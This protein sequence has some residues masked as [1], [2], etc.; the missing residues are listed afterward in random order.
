MDD[1]AP[2][3]T[4]VVPTYNERPNLEELA[5]RVL[6]LGPDYALLVV[7][8]GSP[9]GTGA[10]ADALAAANPGRVSVLHRPRKEGIGPAYLAGFARALAAG[11]PL[12][13]QM[14]ADLSHDPADLP[15]L[16]GAAEGADLVVGS[17]YA[18][19][20]GTAGW[21]AWRRWLSRA[22]CAYARAVLGVEVADLTGGFKVW[23]RPALAGL[24]LGRIAADGYGF[25][26]ETTTRALRTG[27]RVVEVP[28]TFRERVAGRSK[29][30]RRIVG[31]A[32]VL[33][34]RL[35]AEG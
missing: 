8:D 31:E 32:A 14:D 13:A 19:G 1:A 35:R 17:R 29:L 33:V 28:I 9:D 27:A 2:R 34:W 25:Q 30:S 4:V 18:P 5:A 26:I 7:D 21:S 16:V 3:V 11:T 24:D 15:R 22:G 23:R 6:A 12:V 20:G 10:L